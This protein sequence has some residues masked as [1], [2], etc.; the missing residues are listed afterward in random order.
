VL[1]ALPSRRSSAEVIAGVSKPAAI[2]FTF[3]PD[4]GLGLRIAVPAEFFDNLIR[5][6]PRVFEVSA[7]QR[8]SGH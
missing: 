4:K 5:E 6:L 3:A 2:N 7:T 8:L 1:R